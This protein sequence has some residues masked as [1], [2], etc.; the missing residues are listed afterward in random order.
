MAGVGFEVGTRMVE[1][2]PAD[3]ESAVAFATGLFLGGI[4]RLTPG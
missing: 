1:R 3:V 2:E 4:E